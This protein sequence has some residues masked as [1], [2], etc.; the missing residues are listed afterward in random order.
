[1]IDQILQQKKNRVSHWFCRYRAGI[2]CCGCSAHV[3]ATFPSK[4]KWNSKPPLSMILARNSLFPC[5]QDRAQLPIT[6]RPFVPP[7]PHRA[8]SVW[9]VY[10]FTCIFMDSFH[11]CLFMYILYMYYLNIRKYI[12][13][14]IHLVTYLYI[15]M[16]RYIYIC[17]YVL[18]FSQFLY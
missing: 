17:V 14:Y 6:Y 18:L 5:V 16:Y 9:E 1:M 4:Y 8:S 13:I 2:C 3:Q 7:D 10:V 12:Y 15:R 11:L